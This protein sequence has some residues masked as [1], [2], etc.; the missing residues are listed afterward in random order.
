MLNDQVMQ[1]FRYMGVLVAIVVSSMFLCAWLQWA[2]GFWVLLP[3]FYYTLFITWNW[4][5]SVRAWR[6]VKKT[7]DMDDL[8]KEWELYN[9]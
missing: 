1:F 7:T 9:Q 8:D 6:K 5:R 4:L 3:A 2:W